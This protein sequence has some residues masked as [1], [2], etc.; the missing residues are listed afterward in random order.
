MS[1]CL[2]Q[3][4]NKLSLICTQIPVNVMQSK[5]MFR[6]IVTEVN[7]CL[8][9]MSA[10]IQF[11]GQNGLISDGFDRLVSILWPFYTTV[12]LYYRGCPYIILEAKTQTISVTLLYYYW[13]TEIKFFLIVLL[14]CFVFSVLSLSS[15][16]FVNFINN[17]KP[18]N[19]MIT[20]VISQ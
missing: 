17:I 3:F 7:V 16:S 2:D 10:S 9:F 15:T 8:N 20:K 11:D 5:Y 18:W 1:L 14:F 13:E 19:S 4:L 12:E 6:I